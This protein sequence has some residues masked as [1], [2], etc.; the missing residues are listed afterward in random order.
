MGAQEKVLWGSHSL[1][2]ATLTRMG[3]TGK[4]N[5][6]KTGKKKQ[7]KTMR[8]PWDE[9]VTEEQAVMEAG[10]A[11]L[12]AWCLQELTHTGCGRE[13]K[14]LS[15]A[16]SCHSWD[17]QLFGMS[18]RILGC[19][20]KAEGLRAGQ[21]QVKGLSFKPKINSLSGLGIH[22]LEDALGLLR[23]YTVRIC[24]VPMHSTDHSQN[25]PEPVL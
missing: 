18:W 1:Q 24:A 21:Q 22:G 23:G 15:I 10:S 12:G 11:A 17:L 16:W 25:T 5:Q 8:N 19:S 9:R 3:Q 4:K 7:E 13:G 14:A 20:S 2:S 6:E